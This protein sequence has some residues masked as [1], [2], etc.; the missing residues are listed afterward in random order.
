MPHSDQVEL[1]S[2]GV[3][4][5]PR[6]ESLWNKLKAFHVDAF[7]VWSESLRDGRFETRAAGL[8]ETASEGALLV[9]LACQDNVDVG[10]CI[11][12]INRSHAGEIASLFIDESCRGQ[13]LGKR[14][15][16]SSMQW[17][18]E[19]GASPIVVDVMAGNDAALALY[20]EFGFLPRV[21]RLQWS[22]QE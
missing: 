22:G 9:E 19:H 8:Q 20:E 3:E 2:G 7:P 10:F 1:I 15:L 4:L 17:L 5:L 21:H 12:V 11:S 18:Q 13:G 6:I 14:L 16:T